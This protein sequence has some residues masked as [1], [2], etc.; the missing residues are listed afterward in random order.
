MSAEAASHALAN[1][2]TGQGSALL[3]ALGFRPANEAAGHGSA[4]P[5]ALSLGLGPHI[6]MGEV[7]GDQVRLRALQPWFSNS[8]RPVL[9]GRLVPA[10]HGSQLVGRL[11]ASLLVKALSAAALGFVAVAFARYILRI[12]GELLFGDPP[13]I[14]PPLAGAGISLGIM[15]FLTG[16]TAFAFKMGDNDAAFLR[17][18]L[19][20]HLRAPR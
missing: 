2:V 7:E 4:M 20:E 9:T 17:Q 1:E 13:K 12:V 15:A 14:L 6:V 10:P 8:W 18:W 11:G 5:S 19:A 16:L 3:I